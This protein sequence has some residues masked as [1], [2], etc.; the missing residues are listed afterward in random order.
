MYEEKF[1]RF[2]RFVEKGIIFA[3]VCLILL[4]ILTQTMLQ[5]DVVRAIISPVEQMEGELI[6]QQKETVTPTWQSA[7]Q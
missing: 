4:L 7:D 6:Q 2:S 3:L 5:I 1:I